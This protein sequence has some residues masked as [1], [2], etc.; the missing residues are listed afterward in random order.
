LL[1]LPADAATDIFKSRIIENVAGH[2]GRIDIWDVVNEPVNTV[3]WETALKDTARTF[4]LR[5]NEN[6]PCQQL[7][8]WIENAFKWADHANPEA[9]YILN[10]FNMF[11]KPEARER[12]YRL[13]QELL[14][15]DTPV[16]GIGIQAHEPR[17]MW[18]SPVEIQKTFD[19]YQD[20]SLPI[21]ITEFVVPSAGQEI[22][23]WRDGTWN[24][25]LQAEFAEQFYTLTFGNPS[26][27][28]INWWGFSDRYFSHHN[29]LPGG[30]LLDMDY[31]PK[32]VYSRLLKLIKEDWMTKNLRLES[33]K[34]GLVYFRGF[35][36]KYELKITLPDGRSKV[37]KTHLAEND[38]NHWELAL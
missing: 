24:E 26:V 4:D 15:R 38:S 8:P 20:F 17:C 10:E 7:V 3:T 9:H 23:G 30:G 13:I 12:F 32:P 27:E 28:S 19:L 1:K 6:V 16:K 36:G 35:Y 31:H 22:T 25:E 37:F 14:S 34:N 33:D 2:K 18:Y 5:Y 29:W 11:A 21:H